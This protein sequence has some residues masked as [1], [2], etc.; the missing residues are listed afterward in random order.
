MR[1]T[2][3]PLLLHGPCSL[4][5]GHGVKAPCGD[6][7]TAGSLRHFVAMTLAAASSFILIPT[8]RWTLVEKLGQEHSPARLA[9]LVG[10]GLTVTR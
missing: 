5:R 7:G 2:F 3:T 10:H 8:L 6:G 4:L 9:R 1:F